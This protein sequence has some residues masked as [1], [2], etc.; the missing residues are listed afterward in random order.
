MSMKD[1]VAAHL[2]KVT[3]HYTKKIPPHEPRE[4][5][6]FKAD[7]DEWKRRRRAS[8]TYY[9]DFAHKYRD[10]FSEC[11]QGKPLEAHHDLI[12]FSLKNGVTVERLEKFYSGISAIGVGKWIDSD[13]NLTLLCQWHHRGHG[14]V[15][16]L[17]ASDYE[18]YKVIAGLIA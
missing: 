12:E 8:N 16:I 2:M 17:T 6:P 7:F 9:C 4:Q 5:D 18:A 11:T 1:T 14:G 15:H 3:S 10:D 13:A